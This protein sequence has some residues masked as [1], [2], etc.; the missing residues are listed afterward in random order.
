[1]KIKQGY[2]LRQMAQTWTVLPLAEQA[3][4]LNGILTLSDSGALLWNLLEQGCERSDLV[5]G[6]TREYEVTEDKA[7][8]D[9]VKFIEK[10][11][12]FGCLDAD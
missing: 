6:L 1:M 7:R 5:N 2:I 10:L 9:A 3:K 12:Q 4:T 11:K 8:E